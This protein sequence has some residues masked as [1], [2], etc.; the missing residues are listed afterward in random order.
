MSLGVAAIGTRPRAQKRLSRN[1]CLRSATLMPVRTPEPGESSHDVRRRGCVVCIMVCLCW[2]SRAI[3]LMPT[4][5]RRRIYLLGFLRFGMDLCLSQS[6]L[7]WQ[8][9]SLSHPQ[10][11]AFAKLSLL[12]F[13]RASSSSRVPH[14]KHP[15]RAV[16]CAIILA[17]SGHAS[18]SERIV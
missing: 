11:V 5:A 8:L 18:L 7:V 12:S 6:R 13:P 16:S 1:D 17:N 15:T 9:W 10:R 14:S 4:T 2:W 3:R